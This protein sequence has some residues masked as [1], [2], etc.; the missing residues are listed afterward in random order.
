[1]DKKN[2]V[3]NF[4]QGIYGFEDLNEFV[5]YKTDDKNSPLTIMQSAEN[6]NI[7]FLVIPPNLIELDYEIELDESDINDLEI[8]SKEEVVVLAIL[9]ISKGEN[10]SANLKSPIVFSLKSKLGKQIIFEDSRYD[11]RHKVPFNKMES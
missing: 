3:I 1:M 9:T 8:D 7:S 10:I 2:L 11:T 6:S 5:F 4:S